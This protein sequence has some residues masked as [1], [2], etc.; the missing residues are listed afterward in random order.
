MVTE[1]QIE[2][3]NQ[4]AADALEATKRIYDLAATAW[5][6]ISEDVAEQ[7]GLRR[8]SGWWGPGDLRFVQRYGQLSESEKMVLKRYL[9][10]AFGGTKTNPL[11]ES[12]VPFV[13]FSVATRKFSQKP[14]LIYGILRNV[15]W[16]E[17]QKAEIEPFMY[18][19]SEKRRQG[20]LEVSGVTVLSKKGSAMAQFDSRSLFEITDDT[21]GDISKEIIDWFNKKLR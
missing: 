9:Y 21:I 13:L 1:E 10:T 18:E 15:A 11:P 20:S 5:E 16:G 19:I 12:V 8:V 3:A 6:A 2:K 14:A 17:G 4:T 7:V